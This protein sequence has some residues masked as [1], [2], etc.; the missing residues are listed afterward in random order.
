METGDLDIVTGAFGYTGRYITSRLLSTG[1]MVK[2]LTGH[3][4]RPNPF[5]DRI[6]AA[7]FSFDAPA[8]LVKTLQGATTL[9]NT[10]WVRFP[11][12]NVTFEQAIE[13]TRTLVTAA[14]EAGVRRIVHISITNASAGSP[15]PYFRGKGVVERVII[16][17]G[18]SYAIIRP[19]VVF[20]PADILIN[21][22]SWALRRFP[23]FA[24]F[25]DGAYRIQPVFVDDL[26]ELAIGA[27]QRHEDQLMDA[28]GPET[29]SFEEFVRCIG[30]AVGSRARIVHMKPGLA[31]LLTRLAGYLVRDVVLTRDE[32]EGLM[33]GL[34]VSD[35]QPT[36][37]TR[38]SDW[39]KSNRGILGARYASELGRHYR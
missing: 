13:N 11:H 34:L 22:I 20:G 1:R 36:C 30:E 28:V 8:R 19:T 17:S 29:F 5:G 24:V 7:P 6:S 15:L 23:L 39:L 27:G 18:V 10:Y 2:T 9:Y 31:L 14:K 12:G 38:L 32:V 25:G 26:A 33:A 4:E 21:N 16:D 35:G 3:P 37:Q